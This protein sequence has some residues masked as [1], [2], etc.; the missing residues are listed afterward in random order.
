[1]K[2][3]DKARMFDVQLTKLS[4]V[5]QVLNMN[6]PRSG[7][8]NN[9][10]DRQKAI[11]RHERMINSLRLGLQ[12]LETF[13]EHHAGKGDERFRPDQDKVQLR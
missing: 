8:Y 9:D 7:E 10:E 4:D 2:Q 11:D 1:M 5:I 12:L 3:G 6:P 13:Y